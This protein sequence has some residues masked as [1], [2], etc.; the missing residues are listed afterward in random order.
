M[1]RAETEQGAPTHDERLVAT[2]LDYVAAFNA[3]DLAAVVEH[4]TED[5]VFDWGDTMPALVGRDAFTG[6]YAL[7]WRHFSEQLTVA[8][9]RADGDRLSAYLVT[10]INVHHDWPDCPIRPMYAGMRFTVSGRMGYRFRDD[11]ICHIA[12]DDPPTMT[13]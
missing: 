11:R 13:P 5:L 9:V 7:A 6:F 4:L 10:A 3:G 8:D 12:D 2:Y 1:S